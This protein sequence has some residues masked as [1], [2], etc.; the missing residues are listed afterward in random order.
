[1]TR[2]ATY[3]EAIK[4]LDAVLEMDPEFPAAHLWGV[5]R[6]RNLASMTPRSLPFNAS[7]NNWKIGRS[8][9]P[10]AGTLKLF[11]AERPQLTRL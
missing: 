11:P 8:P 3:D 5:V 1:M 9:S 2:V 6:Y 10:L 7:M 4:Q